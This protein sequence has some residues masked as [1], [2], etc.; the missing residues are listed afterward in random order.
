VGLG[1]NEAMNPYLT[2]QILNFDRLGLKR[3]EKSTITVAYAKT[4][5]ITMLRTELLPYLMQ[6]LENS[7]NEKMPQRLF[8]IGKVFH[9]YNNDVS[10][11]TNLAMVSA[12]SKANYS[13]IKS[14][15]LQ[16]L[17]F[18]GISDYTL[19]EF[20]ESPFINGR[21]AKILLGN[22]E[23]GYFGEINPK[24]LYN[25]KIEEP[26]V[27]AEIKLDKC[28]VYALKSNKKPT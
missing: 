6:N 11:S 4:D 20:N 13:E 21:A 7:V 9:L 25:F 28:I 5:A 3:D 19:K 27:A 15:V 14:M 8:E 2:N 12:H 26:V 24:V 22:E 10:E 16:F 17:K 1:F 18:A 23:I